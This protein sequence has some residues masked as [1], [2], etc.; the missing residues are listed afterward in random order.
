MQKNTC[1]ILI[2]FLL[3]KKFLNNNLSGKGRHTEQ[4]GIQ[5]IPNDVILKV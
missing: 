1:Q 3:N 2:K 4:N 5:K